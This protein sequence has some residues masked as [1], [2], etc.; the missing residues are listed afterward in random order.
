MNSQCPVRG[1][2]CCESRQAVTQLR[3]TEAE[4]DRLERSGRMV[5]RLAWLVVLASLIALEV[6]CGVFS[7]GWRDLL[8]VWR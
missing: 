6:W 4:W 5:G 2:P 8:E 3:K 7:Q 1:C